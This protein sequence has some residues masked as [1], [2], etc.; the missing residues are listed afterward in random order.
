MSPRHPLHSTAV[1]AAVLL[2][3][4]AIVTAGSGACASGTATPKQ[5]RSGIWRGE[6]AFG[7]FSFEVCEAGGKV[8]AYTLQYTVGGVT[9]ALRL[10]IGDQVLIDEEDNSFDLSRPEEGVTFHG[11]FSADGKSA[12]G[13]WEVT[14]SGETVY[15]AWALER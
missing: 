13:V 9:Q 10:G 4:A 5:A 11:Q 14:A 2:C 6:T 8:T 12:S 3:L 15:E 1:H 7:S